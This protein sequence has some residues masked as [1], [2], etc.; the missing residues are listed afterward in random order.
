MENLEQGDG[1]TVDRRGD[2]KAESSTVCPGVLLKH[3]LKLC[4]LFSFLL[5]CKLLLPFCLPG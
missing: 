5:A 3:V 2:T 4:R 1:S